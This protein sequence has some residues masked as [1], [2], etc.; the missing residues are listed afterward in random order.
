[1]DPIS[2]TGLASAIVQILG[3]LTSTIHGLYELHGKFSDADFTIHSLIQELSCIQT[4]LT[5]LKEWQ[6][7][8][9]SNVMVSEEFNE[10]LVTAMGGC[11]IIMEVLSED[12]MTLV[13]GSRN[14][15]TI[16]FRLRIRVIWKEDIMKGHQEKLHAQVMALQLLLQVCQW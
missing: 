8:S 10:Q 5:S 6:R 9:S 13:H 3:A 11:Q 12:V 15:G 7:L 16:G 1:M 2:A 4:A 14:D